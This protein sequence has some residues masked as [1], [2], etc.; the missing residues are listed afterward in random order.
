MVLI[1]RAAEMCAKCPS[2]SADAPEGVR[3]LLGILCSDH[4]AKAD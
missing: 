1:T 2:L 3:L 4:T